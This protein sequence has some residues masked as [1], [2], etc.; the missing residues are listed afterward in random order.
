MHKRTTRWHP[1]T[2]PDPSEP[3]SRPRVILLI[4]MTRLRLRRED[5]PY[6]R[7][8]GALYTT[9]KGVRARR[10]D[11]VKYVRILD[12]ASVQASLQKMA[13]MSA[14]ASARHGPAQPQAEDGA[15]GSD[16]MDITELDTG[17]ID[18]VGP[19]G[20]YDLEDMVGPVPSPCSSPIPTAPY[21]APDTS[22]KRA[23]AAERLCASWKLL[24]PQLIAPLLAFQEEHIGKPVPFPPQL[25]RSPTC[26]KGCL[27]Q[28]SLT[29][30]A[31]I[32]D[33][34]A[35]PFLLAFPLSL[36]NAYPDYK[37]VEVIAC[38]CHNL[39]PLLVQHGLFPCSPV[40]PNLAVSV[41]LLEFRKSLFEK[42][43]ESVNAATGVGV[44]VYG[45]DKVYPVSLDLGEVNTIVDAEML[46]E[47]LDTM[48]IAPSTGLD[49]KE[50]LLGGE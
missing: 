20:G 26:Q 6:I 27:Q 30:T 43:L 36:T 5:Q 17:R 4:V 35:L 12:P 37:K 25:I 44:E 21:P 16:A 47:M 48:A 45:A 49:E 28:H 7:G 15:E 33:R 18:M 34:N 14:K 38:A 24:I 13:A 31:L 8:S 39:L 23:D 22:H 46:V 9:P 3:V 11:N 19:E 41:Q 29:I 1:P 2:L 10:S 50:L 32:Y 40:R 42:S